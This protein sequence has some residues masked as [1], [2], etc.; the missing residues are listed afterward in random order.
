M[1]G[2]ET[3]GSGFVSWSD[4]SFFF[5]LFICL[6]CDNKANEIKKNVLSADYIYWRMQES[7][8]ALVHKILKRK[9]IEVRDG[10]SH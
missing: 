2:F 5:F 9:G 6:S 1:L 8:N 3:K 4:R 7:G 10:T